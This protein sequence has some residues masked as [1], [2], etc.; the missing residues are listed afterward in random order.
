MRYSMI[1]PEQELLSTPFSS[2]LS[3]APATVS[4]TYHKTLCDVSCRHAVLFTQ[5]VGNHAARMGRKDIYSAPSG[6][7]YLGSSPPPVIDSLLHLSY[8]KSRSL[9]LNDKRFHL[10]KPNDTG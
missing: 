10:E 5:R 8:N 7:K 2:V 1:G 4:I 9:D 3:S 6:V